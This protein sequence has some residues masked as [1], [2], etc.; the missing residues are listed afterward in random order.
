MERVS[1]TVA[2]RGTF[3]QKDETTTQVGTAFDPKFMYSYQLARRMAW[4]L[5]AGRESF[6]VHNTTPLQDPTHLSCTTGAQLN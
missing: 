5:L 6:G 1:F 3:H 4:D 2:P